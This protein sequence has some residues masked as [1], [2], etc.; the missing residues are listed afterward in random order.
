MIMLSYGITYLL[1]LYS[2]L[3]TIIW[4][5]HP[6]SQCGYNRDLGMLIL[7]RSHGNPMSTNR[8]LN[9]PKR[10]IRNRKLKKDRQCNDQKDGKVLQNLTQKTVT[11]RC[12]TLIKAMVLYLNLWLSVIL[13]GFLSSFTS[14]SFLTN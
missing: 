10:A 4:Q 5:R 11:V 6:L 13:N 8:S 1:I 2:L 3:T 12:R 14:I 7:I 9:I